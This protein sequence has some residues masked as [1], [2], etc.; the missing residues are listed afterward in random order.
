M[1]TLMTVAAGTLAWTL[2]MTSFSSAEAAG[3]GSSAL[4]GIEINNKSAVEQVHYRRYRRHYAPRIYFSFGYGPRYHVYR[5]HRPRYY[6]YYTP[7]YRSYYYAYPRY[8][9]YW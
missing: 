4:Q 3:A 9:R 6:R 8:Y 5:H 2:G 1:K 7:H